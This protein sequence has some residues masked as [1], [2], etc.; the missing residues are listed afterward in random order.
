[1]LVD[2]ARTGPQTVPNMARARAVSRQH[3]Q[4]LV[5]RFRARG[6][7]E[8]AENPNHRR[9]RLVRLT[10]NGRAQVKSMLQRETAALRSL[11]LAIPPQQIRSAARALQTLRQQLHDHSWTDLGGKARRQ[12]GDPE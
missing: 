4:A 12:R 1:L 2:L 9:S 6:L 11:G 5:D 10:R 3:V 8:L 7:V